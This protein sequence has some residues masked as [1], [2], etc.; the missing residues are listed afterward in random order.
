MTRRRSRGE[1]SIYYRQPKGLWVAKLTLPNGKSKLKYAKQQKD[2][3][4]W[5]V[6]QQN[7]LRQGLLP[8]NN[9]ITVSEFFTNY[10]ENVV[11]HNLR[12]KTIQAYE[13]LTRIHI[14]PAFG[15][16]KLA[17]LQPENLQWFYARKLEQGLS[18]RTV[19]YIHSVIRR[20]LK[21]GLRW[22]VITRKV[23]DFVDAPRPIRREMSVYDFEQVKKFLEFVKEDR[24]YPLY[25]LAIFGAFREGEVLGIH[26][27]DCD[28]SKRTINLKHAV[29]YQ[30][31]KG[32]VITEP[33]TKQSRRA[34]K[35]P[36]FA[37]DVLK[38]YI[39]KL[40]KSQ[41]L[42]FTTDSGKPINPRFLV[43]KFKEAIEAA[44]LPEIRFHDLRH[45]SA[46]LL[47]QAKVHP[48]VVQERLG[49]ASIV[50]TMDTYSHVLPD[51]QDEAAE[52]LDKLVSSLLIK[53]S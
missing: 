22:G 40:N 27:E 47:L 21:Y 24:F 15:K 7:Q 38:T 44:G 20:A 8:R 33:K 53:S 39:Q 18:K 17:D 49:H 10:L 4:E 2:V 23:T 3:R 29:Q 12:P 41:G 14:L 6:E 5:L 34:V 28:L 45:T 26:V 42:I 37:N 46:T 16:M 25:I 50:Q 52:Q 48:K 31:G 51:L 13:S 1:G 9:K 35:L 36:V 30:I 11:R 43:R 32:V 19:Q